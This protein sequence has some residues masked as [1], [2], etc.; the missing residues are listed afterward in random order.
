MSLYKMS[1]T[2][3]LSM[4]DLIFNI[5][6]FL[7]ERKLTIKFNQHKTMHE[8]QINEK[9]GYNIIDSQEKLPTFSVNW[10]YIYVVLYNLFEEAVI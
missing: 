5:S 2:Y 8:D 10:I 3:I 1:N 9:L 6:L 7:L 4:I